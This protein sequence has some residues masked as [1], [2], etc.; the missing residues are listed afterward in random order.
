MI[1]NLRLSFE[2]IIIVLSALLEFYS[3]NYQHPTDEILEKVNMIEE[4]R[5][6]VTF[7]EPETL[8]VVLFS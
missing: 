5:N 1:K 6:C 2:E 7:P 3:D 8:R 4:Y